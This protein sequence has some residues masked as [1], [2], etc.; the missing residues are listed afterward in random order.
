MISMCV[1]GIFAT[2]Q[3]WE[4]MVVSFGKSYFTEYNIRALAYL[5]K[6]LSISVQEAK[7]IEKSL[8]IEN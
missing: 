1:V 3:Q 7:G 4:Y 6:G 5:D 8:D 2:E